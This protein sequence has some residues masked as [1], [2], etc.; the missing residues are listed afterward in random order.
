MDAV[1]LAEVNSLV[2][3]YVIPLAW[4]LAGAIVLWIVGG[5]AITWIRGAAGRV[6][7][8]R[9]IDRTLIGYIMVSI[10]V[11]LKIVLAIA[12]L[13]VFG[14]ETTS[15][16]AILAAAGVAIGLA[17]SGLLANFAAGVF[18]VILRPFKAGDLISAGGVTGVVQDI[19]LFA[20]TLHTSDNLK[21]I[22]GNNK[23]FGDNIVNYSATEF[24][25]VDLRAQLHHSVDP[26]D[27]IARLRPRI[28]AIASVVK[29]PPP[30]I[31]ILEYNAAGTLLVVR[32][33]CHNANCWQVY[34]DTNRTIGEAF[35]EA[36]YPVPEQRTATRQIA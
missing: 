27:A 24:R 33:F 21:V 25:A 35:G 22:V 34:F 12:I 31:E 17:W 6:M 14:V 36:G 7:K 1:N 9:A 32:P 11:V 15:F 13:S 16:A 20:T 28:E 19:G 2:T 10:T 30:V 3:Q 4:K 29:A 18:L 23:L 8:A 5:W 26:K